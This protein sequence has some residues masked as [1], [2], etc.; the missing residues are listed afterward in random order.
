MKNYYLKYVIKAYYSKHKIQI[1]GRL[2]V[3]IEKGNHK[4]LTH[5]SYAIRNLSAIS[6]I[7]DLLQEIANVNVQGFE[8][9]RIYQNRLTEL[10]GIKFVHKI[11]RMKIIEAESKSIKI[12]SPNRKR[13]DASCDIRAKNGNRDYYFET[14]DES[15]KSTTSAIKNGVTHFEPKDDDEIVEW[16]KNMCR[17]ASNKGANYLICR[18]PVWLNSLRESFPSD[19]VKRVFKTELKGKDVAFNIE[20]IDSFFEGVYIVK[21]GRY[22]TNP[23]NGWFRLVVK[24]DIVKALDSGSGPE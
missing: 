10:F 9:E 7:N 22:I 5:I 4:V 20:N 18:V 8:G 17:K 3:D 15:S 16:V 6:G 12:L 21:P 1:T 24:K 14:K 11:L 13:K 23:R 19:W 2:Q